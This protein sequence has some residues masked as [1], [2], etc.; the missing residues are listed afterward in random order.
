MQN[1]SLTG[2]ISKENPPVILRDKPLFLVDKD[3]ETEKEFGATIIEYNSESGVKIYFN[4]SLTSF[5]LE[6]NKE[7]FSLLTERKARAVKLLR[8]NLVLNGVDI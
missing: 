5:W 4:S 6:Q 8:I 3:G 7:L 2:V 1:Y